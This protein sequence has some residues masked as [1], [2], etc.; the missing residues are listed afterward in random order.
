MKLSI[1]LFAPVKNLD[2]SD[3]I[4]EGQPL[5]LARFVCESLLDAT[6]ESLEVLKKIERATLAQRV[7][8]SI[9]NQEP[10]SMSIEEAELIRRLVGEKQSPL[11]VLRIFAAFD[12]AKTV[13]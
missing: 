8:D 10:V 11:V 12:S 13:S 6:N 1:D 7:Y 4:V 2:G 9:R 5:R 3:V